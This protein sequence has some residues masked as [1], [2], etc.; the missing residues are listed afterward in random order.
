MSLKGIF[1]TSVQAMNSQAQ[2][3]ANISTNIANVNT[4]GYKAQDTHFETMLSGVAPPNL[5]LLG[6]NTFDFRNVSKQGIIATT[7]RTFDLAISGRGFFVTNTE[8]NASGVWQY[9]RDGALFGKAMTLSSDSNGDGVRDQGTL[10]V[11]ADGSYVYGW[12]ADDDGRFLENNSLGALTP[13][14]YNNNAVFPPKAT[15]TVT[16]QANLAASDTGRQT[17]GLPYVDLE[18]RS[19]TLTLGFSATLGPDWNLDVAARDPNGD[20][21]TMEL[22]PPSISFDGTGRI[23]SLSFNTLSVVIRDSASSQSIAVDLTRL[24]QFGGGNGLTVQNITQDGFIAGRLQNT[25]FTNDGILVGGYSNGKVQNL[26]KLALATFPA[27]N[28]LKAR[29]GNV[30]EQTAEAGGL[31][32]SGIDNRSTTRIVVGALEAS[33]VDLTDQFSKMIVTQRAYSSTATALRTADEMT[34]AARDLKR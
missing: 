22:F 5:P 10:L 34:Q 8:N 28:K 20:D 1:S 12:K 17:V 23:N 3:L 21:A 31:R 27:E 2:S 4:T 25:Y 30:F 24:T 14:L 6:V 7:N 26:Y 11:T 16:L 33:N 15:E 19:R 29:P 18:G 32:L 9:T 13:I